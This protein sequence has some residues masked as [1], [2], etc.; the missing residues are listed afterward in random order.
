MHRTL[1]LWR[2]PLVRAASIVAILILLLGT[3]AT[4]LVRG[5]TASASAA[6][7]QLNSASGRIQHVIYI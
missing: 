7:C 5:V 4:V 2:R 3:G 1:L 6:G